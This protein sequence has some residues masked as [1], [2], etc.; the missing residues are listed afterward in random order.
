MSSLTS[1]LSDVTSEALQLETAI[2]NNDTYQV[3]R[4]LDLHPDTFQVRAFILR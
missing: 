2:R 4:L 3:K 1:S